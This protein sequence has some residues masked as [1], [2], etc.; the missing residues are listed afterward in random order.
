MNPQALTSV[1]DWGERVKPTHLKF[2]AW[3]EYIA[4]IMTVHPRS[5]LAMML[6]PF[7]TGVNNGGISQWPKIRC[8]VKRY[9]T[10]LVSTLP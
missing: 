2:E 5:L 4:E 8:G 3:R 9:T 6:R 7:F 10:S 1:S